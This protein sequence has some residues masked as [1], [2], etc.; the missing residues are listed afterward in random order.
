MNPIRLAIDRPV[1][2]LSAVGMAVLL[3]GLSLA[4]IPIQLTPEVRKPV[5]T[6][7]TTWPGAAPAELEREVLN[8][9]EDALRGLPALEEMSGSART[10][11]GRIRLEFTIGTEMDHVLLLISNRLDGV[12]GYPEEVDAPSI[13][14]SDSDDQP[15]AWFTLRHLPGNDRPIHAYGEFVRDVVQS[16]IERVPGVSLVNVY[17]T[18]ERQ[19]RV[20]VDPET[21]ARFRITVPEMVARLRRENLS[22]SAGDLE[23]GKRRYV[24]RAEG[25]LNDLESIRNVVLR[26]VGAQGGGRVTVGDVAEVRFDVADPT[27][28]IRSRGEAAIGFNVIREA[29]ANVIE[30]MQGVRQAAAEL[31]AG[32][33]PDAGLELKQVYDETVYIVGAIDLV[34][35]NIWVGGAFALAILLLFLRS[36]RATL[37]VALAIPVS[38][39]A[40]FVAMTAL[41]RTLNVISLA[42]IAF[43]VGMVVDAAIVVLENIFRLHQSGQSPSR[44]A[45]AGARQVW[46]AVLVA[47]LTTV[48]VFVPILTIEQEAGQLFR[49]IAV[50]I[51][52]AVLLSLVVSVTVI[53]SLAARLLESDRDLS[54]VRTDR[55]ARLGARIT[56]LIADYARLTTRRP[57]LGAVLVCLVVMA[58]AG[59]A[60]RFLPQL[61]YLPTGNRNLVF[62]VV[63]PPPG[64]SLPATLKIAERVEEVARPHWE[65][66]ED[67][68]ELVPAIQNFFFVALQG[69]SFVGAS[70]K[71]PARA[72]ELPGILTQP[73]YAEPGTFGVIRQRSLFGR[74]IGGAREIRLNVSGDDIDAVY[75]VAGEVTARM[76]EVFPRE[77]G[78][79]FRA[80]PEVSLRA[81][82]I[83]LVPDRG[84]LADAGLDTR[85]MAMTVDA[86]ADGVRVAEV[87]VGSQRL[88][89]VLAGPRRWAGAETRV[90]DVA[91]LP[92]VTAEGRILPLGSL[93][94]VDLTAGQNE[95]HHL[96]RRRNVSLRLSPSSSI[97]LETALQRLQ[98]KVLAP[99]EEAGLPP[100]IQL[101]VSGTADSLAQ[102]WDAIRASLLVAIA[103]VFLLLA[104]LFESFVLPLVILLTAPVAAAGGVGGLALLNLVRKQPLDMLTMLGFVILIGIAVNNAILLVHQTLYGM[105][106]QGLSPGDAIVEATRNRIRPIFMSTLTSV[107]G[108]A[109]LVLFP[110]AGSE[111][112]RGLGSVVVG[113]LLLSALLTLVIVPPLLGLI[114]SRKMVGAVAHG[115]PESARKGGGGDRPV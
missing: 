76:L 35:Q 52:V 79:Q 34:V 2:V 64:Y 56:E 55:L 91:S 45:Y 97:A 60:W 22:A 27:A 38:V 111:L 40:C 81:P 89:L 95:I 12:S 58:A 4:A 11:R 42:G 53:P 54:P 21:L 1:A 69:F 96:E 68:E 14:T 7:T 24:I 103:I 3:G 37:V 25:E 36:A 99:V 77:E 75:Q 29:G 115:P 71:D 84:R 109:P 94:R 23:E 93:V 44:A 106:E 61:E 46:A 98:E 15:I 101:S 105:R 104:V 26:S 31:A 41:G 8:R 82:E 39:V 30:T 33:V 100:G 16:R 20:V 108:M 110:G 102:T 88:D 87:N 92:V 70:A 50:A 80:V 66:E 65:R 6:V 113:G 83:R 78:H 19:I 63:L 67:P 43:S 73:I 59:G 48:L 90:Q 72:R 62:G 85:D 18:A 112:Y 17:G 13:D 28:R 57:G 32:P 9:Q 114:L 10:G 86:Y 107:F 5:V 47:A 49:D 51:S 74:S